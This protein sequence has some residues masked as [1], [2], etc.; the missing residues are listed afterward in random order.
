VGHILLASAIGY[1]LWSVHND[2]G[3]MLR[4]LFD[5]NPVSWLG[6]VFAFM[7]MSLAQSVYHSMVLSALAGNFS[8]S[9]SLHDVAA[10]L[11]AQIVRYLP[12]KV[13]GVLYQADKSRDR[14]SSVRIVA[15]NVWQAIVTNLLSIGV[16]ASFLSLSLYSSYFWLILIFLL[17][18]ILIE[19]LHR[20]N[21]ILRGMKSLLCS[22]GFMND[23]I[24]TIP[25]VNLRWA[26]SFVLLLE[27]VFFSMGVAFFA[28]QFLSVGAIIVTIGWYAISSILAVVAVLV[29]AG[30]AVR[31]AIFVGGHEILG[32][33]SERL[34]LLA[35]Q[36]RLSMVMAEVAIAGIVAFV[37]NRRTCE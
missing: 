12:G 17:S 29:P 33:S 13:W 31:E 34:L 6:S 30:L 7:A 1:L 35:A 5:V 15:A 8:R 16:S 28:G 3:G 22:V 36:V 19:M 9:R 4:L 18:V 24:N 21:P 37:A 10:Y 25:S 11:Q 32:E 26:G 2:A 23:F 14:H 27:W 20:D